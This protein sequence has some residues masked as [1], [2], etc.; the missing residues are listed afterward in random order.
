MTGDDPINQATSALHAIGEIVK[1]AGDDAQAKR[2]AHELGKTAVTVTK[3]INAC[4]LPLAVLNYA[5]DKARTYFES[6]FPEEFAEIAKEIPPEEL[7]EPKAS[8]AGPLLQALAFSHEEQDLKRM[9]LHLLA[10][11]MDRRT[12]E[13]AHPSFVDII[14]HLTAAEAHYLSSTIAAGTNIPLVEFRLRLSGSIFSSR[15]GFRVLLK[16]LPD[17]RDSSGKRVVVP[18][19]AAMIENFCRLGLIE[20]DYEARAGSTRA[21]EAEAYAWIKLRPEYRNLKDAHGKDL[22]VQ[23][24][25]MLPTRFGLMFASAVGIAQK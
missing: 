9:Y 8:L 12:S 2:A 10:S 5:V 11:G 3:F 18:D 15:T 19:V 1:A 25:L 20:V 13:T 24:G 16:H 14:K 17:I 22:I 23:K 21:M 6:R 4:L 7:V